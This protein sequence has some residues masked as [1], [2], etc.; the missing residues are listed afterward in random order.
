MRGGSFMNNVFRL[1]IVPILASR[2]DQR[3]TINV[4]T[5][6]IRT[7]IGWVF[8]PAKILVN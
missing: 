1:K 4:M 2:Q 7:R 3:I 8:S 5:K 6:Q